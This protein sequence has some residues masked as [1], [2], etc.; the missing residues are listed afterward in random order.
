MVFR[1]T[2]FERLD[3]AGSRDGTSHKGNADRYERLWRQRR[4][5]QSSP[6]AVAVSGDSCEAGNSVGTDELVDFATFY[7]GRAVIAQ[8]RGCVAGFR[9]RLRY[10]LRKIL[11]VGAHVERGG[12]IAPDFP[13]RFGVAQ[14]IEEPGFLLSS[15][16]GLGGAVFAEIRDLDA[17]KMDGLGRP[18]AIVSSPRIENFHGGFR[19][20]FGK[21]VA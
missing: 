16:N 21:V 18:T 11:E 7:V 10:S 12:S 9:P 14:T 2:V 13:G 3:D 17:A 1:Q 20:E 4:R 19:H 5:R 8:R 15:E 6:K